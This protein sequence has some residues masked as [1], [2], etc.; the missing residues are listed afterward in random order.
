[1]QVG[2]AVTTHHK[3]EWSSLSSG[4]M[5]GSSK[6]LHSNAQSTCVSISVRISSPGRE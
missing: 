3:V 5:S 2:E 4:N 1:M 6:Y